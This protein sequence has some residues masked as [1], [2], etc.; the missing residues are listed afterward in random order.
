MAAMVYKKMS[1]LAEI[2]L[3]NFTL[4]LDL[5]AADITRMT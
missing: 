5:C 1:D 3:K 2:F 4:S